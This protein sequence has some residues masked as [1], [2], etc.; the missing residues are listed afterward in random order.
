[1]IELLPLTLLRLRATRDDATHVDDLAVVDGALPPPFIVDHAIDDLEAGRPPSWFA[2]LAFVER[3]ADRIV[4]S[5]R[6]KAAPDERGW[7]E[8]GYGVAPEC[9]GRGVATEGVFALVAWA[10]AQPTVRAVYAETATTNLP[11]RRVVEKLGFTH[12]GQRSDGG[13]G[14]VDRW[15]IEAS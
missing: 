8:I 9:Q 7:V 1:M 10:F 15:F 5:A 3:P 11:S 2:P 6:F 13:H 14:L 4:G 12:A